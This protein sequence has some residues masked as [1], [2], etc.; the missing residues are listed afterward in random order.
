MQMNRSIIASLN[1]KSA[2]LGLGEKTIGSRKKHAHA[3][4]CTV[5]VKSLLFK[6]K[7]GFRDKN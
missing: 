6:V 5:I 1:W 4:T 3:A 2:S 7:V